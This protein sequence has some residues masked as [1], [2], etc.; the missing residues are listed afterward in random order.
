M[1]RT[2]EVP[3]I[4]DDLL[5]RVDQRARQIGVDRNSYLKKVIE[6]AVAPPYSAATLAELLTPVHDF[7][8]AHGISEKEI[9]RFFEQQLAESR[10]QRQRADE[11]GR[12]K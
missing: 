3:G 9:Q 8:E 4:S 1:E 11:S 7:T 12:S 5:A 10:R 2:I 6:R